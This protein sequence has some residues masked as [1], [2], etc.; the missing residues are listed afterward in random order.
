VKV[1]LKGHS[2]RITGLAF[3]NVSS[4]LVSSGADAQICVWNSDGWEKQRSRFLQLPSSG[5]SQ[6]S[7]SE[8]RVQFHQDQIHF[9][10]AHESQLAIYDASKLE[11]IKQWT[12]PRESCVSPISYATFS[13]DSQLVY[14]SLLDATVCIFS[15][16][17][18][19]LRCR[20]NPS[21]YLP[22]NPRQKH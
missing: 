20:I 19:R 17:H 21:A 4:V 6:S 15:A 10:V 5:R 9:L 7:T 11:C 13:C 18:L 1:K 3:S 16:M 12:P 2:K 8:T 22:S 14:A